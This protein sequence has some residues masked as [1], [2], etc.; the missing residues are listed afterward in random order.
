M[1]TSTR[2]LRIGVIGAGGRG[3]LA[4]H[5]HNPEDGVSVVAGVDTNPVALK[6]FRKKYGDDAYVTDDYRKMLEEV[7]IDAV[8]V[9]SPDFLHEEHAVAA[10]EA[11][12]DV[13]LEK[14]IE[15]TIEGADNILST[16]C[17]NNRKLYLGH[18][19]RHMDFVLKM[20]QLI[21]DGE[22]G[23]VKAG[24]CRHFVSYGG[25]AYFKDW[26]A[27]RSK[28]TGLLLQKGAHDIDVL[29]WLCGAYS[30]RVNAFGNLSVYNQID[31]SDSNS[32]LGDTSWHDS[33]WPPLSQRGLHP[34]IEVE[35]LSMMQMV[36]DN[37]VICSYQQCHYTPDGWRNYT[38]IGTEGRIENF[39]DNPG[40][41]VV[42]LWN[43][44]ESYNPYGDEQFYMA[45]AGGGHG[46]ADPRIVGEFVRFIRDGGKVTTSPVAARYSVAAGV[47]ATES[48]RSNGQPMD[49]PPLDPDVAAYFN[50]DLA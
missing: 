50:K 11:G 48:L 39:G 40:E 20:K 7:D 46:G 18:N 33:N 43:R 8:F 38:I 26:H 37:D 16:A 49:V 30:K 22:I 6:N 28:Q 36:L 44:R 35:D 3:G 47:R 45:P 24:W 4:D 23:E 41:C 5:S 34:I 13:Y 12:K 21:D 25:D 1:T 14:P 10:L 29:H 31:E 15:I 19:M 42:R 9:C 17:N 2:E 27:E 32:E